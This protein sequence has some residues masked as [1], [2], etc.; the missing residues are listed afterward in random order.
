MATAPPTLSV[1]TAETV[2]ALVKC[3]PEAGRLFWLPRS[4][5]F[6]GSKNR[7]ASWNARYAGQE[8][9]ACTDAAGYKYGALFRKNYLAHRVIWLLHTGSWPEHQI[10]HINGDCGDNRLSNLRAATP[11]ENQKNRRL[12]SRNKSGVNGVCWKET[13]RKWVAQISVDRVRISLGRFDFFEDA[14]AAR[15]AANVK[16]GFSAR[17]GLPSSDANN[18]STILIGGGL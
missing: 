3:E 17:H 12:H 7:H 14:V 5:E 10:D 11:G 1:L 13:D 8:A 16:Y 4:P 15:L 9:F 6:F 18:T 2:R